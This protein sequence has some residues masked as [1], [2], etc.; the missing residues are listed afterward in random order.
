MASYEVENQAEFNAFLAK[1]AKA[2]GSRFVMGEMARIVKKFSRANFTLKGSGQYPPLTER[3]KKRK[4]RFKPSAP[5]LVFRG[6]LRDSIIGNTVN[7]ILKITD[8]TAI[9][10]TK[11][12][13]G[14]FHDQGAPSIN[15]P[16]RKPLFLT[17]KMVEQII[18]T[19]SANI[20]KQLKA[21]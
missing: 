16:I 20:D 5:I 3:Y 21:L 2:G 4:K 11:V 7:S 19:Y 17:K 1:V 6:D 12:P 9:V 14:K 18:K 15:L 13:H 10:G 8:R